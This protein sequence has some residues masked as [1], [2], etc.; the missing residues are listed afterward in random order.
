MNDELDLRAA[1][2]VLGHQDAAERDAMRRE[3][4]A[5]PELRAAVARWEARFYPLARN[6]LAEM[7]S[8]DLLARIKAALPPRQ[9]DAVIVAL[10]RSV[11]RWQVTAGVCGALAATLIVF[12]GPKLLRE[13]R[14]P[15]VYVAAVNR[16]GDAP[17]L[18]VRVD[19]ASGRVFVRPVA[20]E[21]PSG[22]S[23]ELWY[24]GAGA[25]PRSMGVLGASAENLSLPA[26]AKLEKAQFAVT[27][28]QPG[29]SPTGGPTGPVVYSGELIR[30]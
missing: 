20:A 26:G 15:E 19:L 27:V 30:Q 11:R 7:P 23:L 6:A 4:E 12:A 8:A 17:A 24:I 2:Y 21:T 9:T 29:G 16:G 1:E 13:S 10:R 5:N 3:I 18:I 14:G 25:P 22:K 28:E